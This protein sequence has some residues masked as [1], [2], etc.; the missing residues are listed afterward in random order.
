MNENRV[1]SL[2]MMRRSLG[3]PVLLVNA[4][5][6]ND[7]IVEGSPLHPAFEFLSDVHK[8][9]YI[10]IYLLHHY[11]GGWHDIKPTEISY[12][13]AWDVFA[14]PEVYFVGKPEIDGGAA[15]VYD[16][17]GS[18]MPHVWQ[19]LVATNRWIGRAHTPLSRR[20]FDLIN[21][22]LDEN[23]KQL[24]RSPAHNAYSHKDDRRNSKLIR[25]LLGRRYPLQWTLFGDLFHPLNYE[26]RHNFSRTLPFDAVE[27]MGLNYR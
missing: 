4:E 27:N 9:D 26:F 18:Y 1:R 13:G 22:V 11:G 20:L 21:G 2:E 15:C 16:D 14:D 8:S 25:R 6:I 7:F 10:R 12:S 24:S 17:E 3:V 19:G 5:N 23:Y